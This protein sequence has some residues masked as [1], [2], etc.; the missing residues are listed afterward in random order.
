L[1]A[2]LPH[3]TLEKVL[4]LGHETWRFDGID[5]TPAA[6][7]P[8]HSQARNP[9]NIRHDSDD[10]YARLQRNSLN[11]GDEEPFHGTFIDDVGRYLK[12]CVSGHHHPRRGGKPFTNLKHI[13]IHGGAVLSQ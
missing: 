9:S 2:L 4:A 1:T 10:W 7:V 6:K 11:G 13:V 8:K 3:C 5:L 12:R